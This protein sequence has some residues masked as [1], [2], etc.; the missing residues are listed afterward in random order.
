MMSVE[1]TVV[2]QCRVGL[3]RPTKVPDSFP[4]PLGDLAS[5]RLFEPRSTEA[6]GAIEVTTVAV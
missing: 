3:V 5:H 4:I 6:T 1:V 2:P